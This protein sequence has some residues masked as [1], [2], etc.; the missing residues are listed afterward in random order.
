MPFQ[1]ISILKKVLYILNTNNLRFYVSPNYQ[2]V[3]KI[4]LTICLFVLAWTVGTAQNNLRSKYKDFKI[5][6]V[7][8][9]DSLQEVE[10]RCMCK[11]LTALSLTMQNRSQNTLYITGLQLEA[12]RKMN[13]P[14]T[15][16]KEQGKLKEENQRGGDE[17]SI[18]WV[19]IPKEEDNYRYLF[20]TVNKEPYKC[21][22]GESITIYVVLVEEKTLKLPQKVNLV[23]K[24]MTNEKELSAR[25]ELITFK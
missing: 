8:K 2:I 23:L 25:S 7:Q 12:T 3:M 18:W 5:V 11:D 20:K 13:L 10:D 4:F 22:S 21:R 19:Y 1:N 24:F 6:S 17:K 9:I 16:K 15:D 14:I